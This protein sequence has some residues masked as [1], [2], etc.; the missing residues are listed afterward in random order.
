MSWQLDHYLYGITQGYMAPRKFFA[1]PE[2]RKSTLAIRETGAD[3]V[4]LIVNQFQDTFASTH[5]SPDNFHTVSDED[6]AAQ[7]GLLHELGFAVMLKPMIDPLDSIWRGE[8]CLRRSIGIIA[9]RSSDPVTPWFESYLEMLLRYAEVASRT[10]CEIFCLGCELQ[11]MEDQQPEWENI[12]DRIREVYSGILTYNFNRD[13]ENFN[14]RR[15]W[16]RKLDL[17]GVSGYFELDAPG[18]GLVAAWTKQRDR[19]RRFA[20]WVG[21]PLFFAETG[22]RPIAGAARITGDFGRPATV[23]S[24]EEQAGYYDSMQEVF[25]P[26]EWFYGTVW[27][28]HD[29]HQHRPH[30]HLPDGNYAGCEPAPLCRARMRE[31]AGFRPRPP[32]VPG[33]APTPG[34]ATRS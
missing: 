3:T 14:E 15:G 5:I 32:I 7:I 27:W 13:V 11:Y 6:L 28:K 31:R 9:G 25:E 23:Y 19:L 29:E 1:S 10:S 26:E 16:F 20:D 30:F 24:E 8:I 22:A 12:V 4:A 21:R 33:A 17:V 34:I 2:G 18:D